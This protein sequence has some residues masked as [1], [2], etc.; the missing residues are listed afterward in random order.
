VSSSP[1]DFAA[2]QAAFLLE[3]RAA[4][5]AL[6]HPVFAVAGLPIHALS[7]FDQEGQRGAVVLH[8]VGQVRLSVHSMN[9]LGPLEDVVRA[10]LAASLFETSATNAT[11]E[12]EMRAE[13]ETR[14]AGARERAAA[15]TVL[16]RSFAVDGDEVEFTFATLASLWV[17]AADHDGA[18]LAVMSVGVAPD[19][20]GLETVVDPASHLPA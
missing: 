19:G 16:P 20:L 9:P 15:V 8:A 12:D 13:I 6:G 3:Q 4:L 2:Q 10:M 14:I 18:R 1:D 11:S 7:A 5:E 17:A